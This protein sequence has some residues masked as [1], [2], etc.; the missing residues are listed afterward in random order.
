VAIIVMCMSDYVRK[1]YDSHKREA[2][3]SKER[4]LMERKTWYD[5]LNKRM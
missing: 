5:V 2:K 1:R 4:Y 3:I